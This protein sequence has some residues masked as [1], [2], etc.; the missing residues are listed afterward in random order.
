MLLL[1]IIKK[2]GM[3]MLSFPPYTRFLYLAFY[4]ELFCNF[5]NSFEISI[6]FWVFFKYPN[7]FSFYEEETN[8]CG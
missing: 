5:I 1:E 2:N 7:C 4:G 8:I 6:K 3:G